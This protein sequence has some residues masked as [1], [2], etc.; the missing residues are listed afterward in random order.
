MTP[1]LRRMLTAAAATN[2]ALGTLFAWSILLRPLTAE[3]GVGPATLTTVFSASLVAF[4]AVV[5][6]GGRLTDTRSP[7]ALTLAAAALAGGGL[8]LTA[9]APSVAVAGVAYGGLFGLASGLGYVTAV[10]VATTRFGERRGLALGLVVGAYAAGPVVVGPLGALAIEGLG[11]RVTVAGLAVAVAGA[12]AAAALWMPP[13]PVARSDPSSPARDTE[14]RPREG[15]GLWWLWVLFL[16]ATAPALLAFAYTT[17]IAIESDVAPGAAGIAVGV[18]AA[19]TSAAARRRPVSD[20]LGTV[21][22]S[23]LTLI[24]LTLAVIALGWIG[25][26]GVL[27]VALALLG[28]QY[29]AISAL[30][31]AATADLVGPERFGS[32]YGRAFTSW[33][34]AGVLGPA[35]GGWLHGVSGDYTA[36]L[37]ALARL[38]RGRHRRARGV[39][40]LPPLS[41]RPGWAGGGGR[42]ASGG[43][44]RGVRL[45]GARGRGVLA[46]RPAGDQHHRQQRADEREAGADEERGLEALGQRRRERAGSP[47]GAHRVVGRR[48]GDRGE[49]RQAERAAD[50]LRGVD[51]PGGE[52]RLVPGDAGSPRR[53]SPA[54]T[55]SRGRPRP[56]ATGTGRRPRR[57]RPARPARTTRA[58]AAT[59]TRPLTSTGLKPKRVTSC[60]ATPAETMIVSASGR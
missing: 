52:A 7:R 14:A 60:E 6:L 38:R 51:Q 3:Y 21:R 56:A 16:G 46:A 13:A 37:P 17:E 32:G 44:R 47:R 2:F 9:L 15:R 31:P 54:R 11:W 57:C 8:A 42:G 19:A 39:R 40:A 12:T 29:G 36:G 30:L 48:R 26:V 55:R 28:T 45:A 18:L 43:D 53:S 1:P 20:R 23:A 25:S 41:R 27:L 22:T 35:A 4:A 34:V 24:G 58:P 33:G 59:S 10:T 50:L 49:D 5:L